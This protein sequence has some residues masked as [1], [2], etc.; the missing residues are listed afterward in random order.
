MGTRTAKRDAAEVPDDR[1][2]DE[3]DDC[4]D[5]IEWALKEWP[6]ID[7]DVEAIVTRIS[8]ADR[9][10]DRSSVD[11]L[12]A[13]GLAHGELKVLLRLSRGPRAHG[14]IARDLL[15]STGTMTN[16]LDKLEG[17]GLVQRHA[18]PDDRRGVIVELTSQ[19]R[20]AL[21]RYIEVQAKRERQLMSSMSEADKK[22]L[23]KLLRRLLNALESESSV[24][25][26]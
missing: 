3:T 22:E 10:I 14:N 15:V 17:A 21:D 2:V 5:H 9:I 25:K 19:G 11:T 23:G 18:D 26:R 16:R 1:T 4:D 7:P 20:A 24:L 8:H 13:V 6:D 12:E